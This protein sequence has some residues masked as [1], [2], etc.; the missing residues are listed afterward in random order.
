MAIGTLAVLGLD[1]PAHRQ[2]LE[3]WAGELNALLAEDPQAF[4]ER[5]KVYSEE[6]GAYAH[7]SRFYN[8]KQL[9]NAGTRHL[10][11]A[12][13]YKEA[14]QVFQMHRPLHAQDWL[15]PNREGIQLGIEGRLLALDAQAPAAREAL[16][17]ALGEASL[18]FQQISEA[19]KDPLQHPKGP[20][21]PE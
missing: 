12:G 21:K 2:R 3:D 17:K 9:I 15:C 16:N 18:W 5:I 20:G 8:I 6:L 7:G 13:H 10:A 4:V 19:K 11:R 1:D 14:L